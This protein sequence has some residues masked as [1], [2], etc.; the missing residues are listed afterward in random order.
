MRRGRLALNTAA[1]VFCAIWIFPCYWM[2]NTAF[3]PRHDILSTT[4]K[5]LPWPLTF[6]NFTD[7]VS[8]PYFLTYL[9]NSVVVAGSVVAISIVVAFLASVALTRFRFPGRRGFLAAILLMLMVPQQA[10]VIPL[11]LGLKSLDL[12]NSLVGLTLTYVAFVLPFTIWTLRGFLQGIPLELEEAA[13]VD[14]AGRVTVI[15]KI[16]LP[17]VFPGVVATSIFALITAWNDYIFAYVMMKD[18]AKYTLPVWLVSFS[19]STGTDYGGLIAG[20][21]LF[22]LPVVIFFMVL[23]RRLVAGMTSGAVKG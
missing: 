21:T 13:M 6:G 4:P 20:S 15:R 8:R 7:A 3:K 1:L 12:L 14:G 11:F 10:L 19:T 22:T 17:L 5:L 23:Q 18:Q 9:R 16:L 2:L